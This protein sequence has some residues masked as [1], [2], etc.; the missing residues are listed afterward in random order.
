VSNPSSAF[1][2][3]S[4]ADLLAFDVC[5]ASPSSL[6]LEAACTR[7]SG[8]QA[9]TTLSDLMLRGEGEGSGRGE[10]RGNERKRLAMFV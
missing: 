7:Y 10:G 3:V 5:T 1:Y 2:L 9:S 4:L 8:C 6:P